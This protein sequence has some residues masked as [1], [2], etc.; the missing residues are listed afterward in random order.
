MSASTIGPNLSARLARLEIF[1][2]GFIIHLY[3]IF[4]KHFQAFSLMS[5]QL[6]TCFIGILKKVPVE[7]NS[8]FT[9]SPVCPSTDDQI[10]SL[11]E[12]PSAHCWLSLTSNRS[13]M[14]CCQRPLPA[15]VWKPVILGETFNLICF[16]VCKGAF[17]EIKKKKKIQLSSHS[18]ILGNILPT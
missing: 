2:G 16:V 12:E 17:R 1:L 10:R 7:Q 11:T 18:Q 13:I 15:Y 14:V 4:E 5:S 9:F 6:K 8:A 3:I